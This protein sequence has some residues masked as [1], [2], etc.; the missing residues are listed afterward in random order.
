MGTKATAIIP[1]F[2]NA[3]FARWAIKSVQHQTV[4][5]IEICIICDGSPEEMVS[6]FKNMEREDSRIKVFEFPK[7][8]RT[9]E[10]YRD[11]VIKQTKGRIICYCSHD[12]LWLP[13]HIEEM[14]RSLKKCWFTHSIHAFVNLPGDVKDDGTL[15]GGILWAD[16]KDQEIINKMFQGENFFGLTFGAHTRKSYDKLE[17][18][19]ATTPSKDVPTDLYMWR[20]FLSAFRKRCKT[21][22]K[23]TALNFQQITRKDWTEEERD[24]ELKL[25]FEKIQGPAFLKKVDKLFFKWCPPQYQER[26]RNLFKKL[27]KL[28]K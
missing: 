27:R 17:E 20:K 26:E 7:S 24:D 21:T 11:A 6:F 2:G 19:W 8:P 22:M 12:D 9:G 1:T 15:F 5:N 14:E 16:L 13:H 4:R 28:F 18:G 10:P 23:I 25:Y 3:R